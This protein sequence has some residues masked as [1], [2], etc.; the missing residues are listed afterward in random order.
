MTP[1]TLLRTLLFHR[2]FERYSGGHGKVWD[3]FRHTTTA[4]GWAAHV[5]LTPRSTAQQNPW[6]MNGASPM[7]AWA[8]EQ[9]NAL[10]LGGLDWEAYPLSH[11]GIPVVN[12]VQHVRHGDPTDPRYPFL[13]RPA[14]RICVSDEVAQAISERGSPNGPV[15]VIEAAIELPAAAPAAGRRGIFIDAIKQPTLGAEL[16]RLLAGA[17]RE[18]RL[19]DHRIPRDDYLAELA[20]AHTAVVLPRATEGFYLPGLEA[21]ALGCATIVPDC[22]GNRAYLRHG[23]NALAPILEAGALAGAVAQFDDPTLR[24]RLTA[25]GLDTARGFNMAGER[26]AFHRVLDDLPALWRDAVH[27]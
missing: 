2:D 1:A 23:E 14:V 13:R 19:N 26:A 22:I 24:A 5:Y 9:A 10:F 4:S 11:P 3:Y 7:Q 20:R 25:A 6:L 16:A 18:V 27:G 21:M 17:G 15:L 12:L 8:P